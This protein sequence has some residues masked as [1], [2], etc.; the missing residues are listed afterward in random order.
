MDARREAW[1]ANRVRGML[2][3]P[4]RTWD[5]ISHKAS[6]RQLC[7]AALCRQENCILLKTN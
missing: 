4:L 1:T 5:L 3:P 2:D 7:I 6:I